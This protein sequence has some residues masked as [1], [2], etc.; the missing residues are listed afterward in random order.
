MPVI[1]VADEIPGKSDFVTPQ[2]VIDTIE[3][4]RERIRTVSNMILTM[5]GLLLSVSFA[6]VPFAYDKVRNASRQATIVIGIAYSLTVLALLLSAYQSIFASLL[7]REYSIT[8]VIKFIDD[9]M[10]LYYTELLHL[11]V[12]FGLLVAAI[13]FAVVSHAMFI[14]LT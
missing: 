3:R 12:A 11:R 9:L 4:N 14:C 2:L 13:L 1:G 6:V 10:E 7:R 5:V 8:T